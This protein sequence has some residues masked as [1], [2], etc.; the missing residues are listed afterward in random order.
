MKRNY[1]SP[2]ISVMNTCSEKCLCTSQ[3]S[4][5]LPDYD[6]KTIIEENF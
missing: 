4:F 1:L 5:L 2:G 6:E 3:D